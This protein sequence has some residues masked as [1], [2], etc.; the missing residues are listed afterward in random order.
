MP[1]YYTPLQ[2]AALLGLSKNT[3]YKH[4]KDGTIRSVRLGE[5]RIRIPAS[6]LNNLIDITEDIAH[7][8]DEVVVN[9]V[10][11]PEV[12]DT[13]PEE[14]V[15]VTQTV[16][17]PKISRIDIYDWFVGIGSSMVSLALFLFNYAGINL[18]RA[19]VEMILWSLRILLFVWGWG[20]IL[21]A[22][23]LPQYALRKRL[24]YLFGGL[25]YSALVATLIYSNSVAGISLYISMALGLLFNVGLM[26][27]PMKR[28]LIH[29]VV[30]LVAMIILYFVF[31]GNMFALWAQL[32]SNTVQVKIVIS[33]V[34]AIL[35]L[36]LCFVLLFRNRVQSLTIVG[37]FIFVGVGVYA[38]Y[39]C[40]LFGFW[41]RAMLLFAW[42]V[43]GALFPFHERINW[44]GGDKRWLVA[45][46]IGVIGIMVVVITIM[47]GLM[48]N[49]RHTY[50]D[51]STTTLTQGIKDDVDREVERAQSRL[52]ATAGS[53]LLGA[54]LVE[55]DRT[56]QREYLRDTV[57]GSYMFVQMFLYDTQGSVRSYYPDTNPA[58]FSA[59]SEFN[60]YYQHALRGESFVS[61]ALFQAQVEGAPWL[62][63][64]AVP[65]VDES[66]TVIGVLA[67]RLNIELLESIVGSQAKS[68][69]GLAYL[70]DSKGRVIVAQNGLD[71]RPL[72]ETGS[73]PQKPFL[74]KE[75]AGTPQIA[76][77]EPAPNTPAQTTHL[78]GMKT[79]CCGW[80]VIFEKSHVGDI[81][82]FEFVGITLVLGVM[83][84]LAVG[85][86]IMA[87]IERSNAETTLLKGVV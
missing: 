52:K 80:R 40:V 24:S 46:C 55:D 70:L 61:P 54:A 69:Q 60:E 38:A 5:G 27:G 85:V 84:L 66:G 78:S 31:P 50:I 9:D 51:A 26:V 2:A 10:V 19:P 3:M 11:D 33:I 48:T 56:I 32:P 53:R 6:E 8:A 79:G 86:A 82:A 47:A 75:F 44:G 1:K 30:G 13:T 71:T 59:N 41:D 68:G 21:I 37:H 7:Q 39:Y 57:R 81:D 36:A 72:E 18:D 15:D 45:E 23:L 83:I 63:V 87:K 17:E 35:V 62:I 20:H 22:L 74:D 76:Q 64:I 34:A 12:M 42:I 77:L 16:I 67:G 29:L 73:I 25:I 49:L 43:F 65:M 58:A 28:Y 14:I 4:I